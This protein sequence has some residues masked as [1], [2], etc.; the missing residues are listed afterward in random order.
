MR[1]ILSLAIS[2]LLLSAVAAA[3][4]VRPASGTMIHAAAGATVVSSA[5]LS[6]GTRVFVAAPN[7]PLSGS[8]GLRRMQTTGAEFRSFPSF[9]VQTVSF[10]NVPGLGFDYPHLAAVTRGQ[11]RQRPIFEPLVPL[12][13]QGILF[14]PPVVPPT[15]IIVQQPPV[16]EYP[17]IAN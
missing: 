16:V 7:M 12:G 4:Q 2:C 14:S 10:D 9:P 15:V 6:S 3:Q 8:G 11:P 13:F 5:A 1:L 17:R